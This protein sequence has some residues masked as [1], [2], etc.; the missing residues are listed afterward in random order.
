MIGPI[1]FNNPKSYEITTI[2]VNKSEYTRQKFV[3]HNT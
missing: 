2:F 3:I 1:R